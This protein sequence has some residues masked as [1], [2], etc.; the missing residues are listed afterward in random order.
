M[1]VVDSQI[2]NGTEVSEEEIEIFENTEQ[3]GSVPYREEWKEYLNQME[4]K[5]YHDINYFSGNIREKLNTLEREID[6]MSKDQYEKQKMG[7]EAVLP[8]SKK[9]QEISFDPL[10]RYVMEMETGGEDRNMWERQKGYTY[11]KERIKDLFED[12]VRNMSRELIG[13]GVYKS[14]ISGFINGERARKDTKEIQGYVKSEAKRLFN[15]F[16]KTKLDYELQQQVMERYNNEKNSY[17]RPRYDEIPVVIEGMAT[18]FRGKKFNL[19]ET[20]RNGV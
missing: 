14:D 19:S 8:K 4:G 3:D 5:F 12:Y 2:I 10:D 13:Y 11:K 17:V 18:E 16:M 7:L 6:H 20:Q 9:I 1:P 15:E